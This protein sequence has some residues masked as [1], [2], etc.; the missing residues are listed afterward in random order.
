MIVRGKFFNIFSKPVHLMDYLI[1][2]GYFTSLKP[3]IDI[4]ILFVL[5][6]V[7]GLSCGWGGVFKF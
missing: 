4:S 1:Y 3:Q 6:S 7:G 2:G 5:L